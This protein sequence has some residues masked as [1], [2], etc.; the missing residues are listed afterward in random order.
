MNI[1]AYQSCLNRGYLV[2]YER[3]ILCVE[4]ENGDMYWDD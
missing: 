4:K 3:M 2:C 1:S